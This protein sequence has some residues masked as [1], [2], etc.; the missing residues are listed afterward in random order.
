MKYNILFIIADQHNA[1]TLG[2]YGH[3]DVR[4]P[5][6]DQLAAD[7][8]RFNKAYTQ[9]PIC[10]PSRMSIF[11]GQYP[12]NHGYFGLKGRHPDHLPTMLT[13]FKK[14]G[15]VN[16]IVGK[17]HTPRSW[18]SK[19][20]DFVKDVKAHEHE[21]GH[22]DYLDYL[23][24]KGLEPDEMPEWQGGGQSYDARAHKLSEEDTQE[25]WIAQECMRFL[26]ETKDAENP[27]FLYMSMPKP[28]Q[29]YLPAQRFWDLY[30]EQE[31]TL[32][33]NANDTVEGRHA[34]VKNRQKRF[35]AEP[36]PYWTVFEPRTFEAGRRRILH[37]Y[38]GCV[39]MVD[40][41]A[42]KVLNKI[43]QLG[44]RESTIV[45][46]TSD[47]GD[48]AGEHGMIEKAPG[49]AFDAITR[50]PMIWRLP[51]KIKECAVSQ[52][53]VETIDLF[54]TLCSMNE[55]PI[56]D[57]CDGKNIQ[58]IL[59]GKELEVRDVAVTENPL[60]KTIYTHEYKLVHYIEEMTEGKDFGELY[61]L[62]NDP[63]ELSNLYFQ[64]EYSSVIDDLRT[65]LLNWLIRTSRYQTVHPMPEGD[66]YEEDNKI[67]LNTVKI[68]LERRSLNYL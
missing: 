28:H 67:G 26:E 58:D 9:S 25:G 57:Y 22:S 46:Y 50:V 10:T 32:P 48:F 24:N 62:K 6:L 30:N 56:P 63:W 68:N 27:F 21:D 59:E 36:T 19:D 54:P 23:A 52:A 7:G 49:I 5:Y 53:L 14:H 11:T 15:Y 60:T 44:K 33:C 29:E 45:I 18:M 51:G 17:F 47:H 42:G 61:D 66:V 1:K 38:Y 34:V 39:S 37:G 41:A 8:M 2:C 4:T 43:E 35:Q 12:H 65:R 64:E 20:C 3:P 40:D 55:I 16:G 13:H 31:L